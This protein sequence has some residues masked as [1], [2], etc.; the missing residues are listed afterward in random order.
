MKLSP[1]IE[2]ASALMRRPSITP[3]DAGCQIMIA[4][5]LQALG[6]EI[7]HLR[8]GDVDNL[9]AV[10][11]DQGPLFC[12]AG[13]T[14]V[15]PVGDKTEWHVA[16]F[17][18][19]IKD[20]YLIGR[21][22]ADMKGSLAAML[23]ACE[24]F[25]H[26]HKPAFR[27]AWLITSDEEGKAQDGTRQVIAWLEE[28]GEKIDWCLVGEPS[29][30][31]RVGDVV[32]NGRRGS[33]GARL[34]IRGIQGHVAYPQLA[35]NPIHMAI[36]ALGELSTTQWDQGNAFFPATSFQISN[37]HAGTGAPN[38]IPGLLEVDFNFRFCTEQTPDS[39]QQRTRNILDQYSLN[40]E[41]DWWISGLPFLTAQGTLVEAARSAILEITGYSTQLSTSGGTSDGRFIAPT[42]AQVLEL[43]PVNAS[44]H[45]VNEQVSVSELDELSGIYE[46]VLSKLNQTV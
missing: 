13:H 17:S 42:G 20:D 34:K 26:N 18:A 44:I 38:V 19:Q 23:T 35:A 14:D 43:G 21:G 37:I 5:R 29:S 41:L 27:L 28:I 31:D 9:W 40:Y 1:T 12:F 6:F 2:F 32:K 30:S 4:E 22:A 36:P 8:F 24:R 39:L 45:K 46:A 10:L 11:G 33:M 7:R 25:L 15:V 3:E 16:P